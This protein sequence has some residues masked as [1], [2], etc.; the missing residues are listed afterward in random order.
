M[1]DC[2]E[3]LLDLF[4]QSCFLVNLTLDQILGLLVPNWTLLLL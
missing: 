3:L 2:F 1:I 4:G